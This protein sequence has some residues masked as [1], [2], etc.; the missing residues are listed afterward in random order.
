[1]PTSSRDLSRNPWCPTFF[2]YQN[3]T[4]HG[5]AFPALVSN[6]YKEGDNCR[7]RNVNNTGN[8]S[9][10]FI[11]FE[12]QNINQERNSNQDASENQAVLN[13]WFHS[14]RVFVGAN[15]YFSIR[16]QNQLCSLFSNHASDG[17]SHA[18]HSYGTKDTGINLFQDSGF[19][20]SKSH[21]S[22]PAMCNVE[23]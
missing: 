19:G 18:T 10:R 22:A 11:F 23:F 2:R 16:F 12:S 20:R 5:L 1:M 6:G 8:S 13:I 17:Y 9:N 7:N 3:L 21:D 15:L 4:C 14:S